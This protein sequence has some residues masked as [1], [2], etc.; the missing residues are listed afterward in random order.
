MLGVVLPCYRRRVRQAATKLALGPRVATLHPPLS[1]FGG[2]T[3]QY[4]NV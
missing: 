4:Y 3:R 1:E 2:N